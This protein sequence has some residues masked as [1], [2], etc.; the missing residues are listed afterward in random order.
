[1]QR[2]LVCSQAS[3][4]D[5]EIGLGLKASLKSGVCMIR[6]EKPATL[7]DLIAPEDFVQA[8]DNSLRH[9][10]ETAHGITGLQFRKYT[11]IVHKRKGLAWLVELKFKTEDTGLNLQPTTRSSG[12][13]CRTRLKKP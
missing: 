9:C 1:M 8:I 3:L 11:I 6:D 7:K 4:N 12:A 13:R 5:S 2:L 10:G